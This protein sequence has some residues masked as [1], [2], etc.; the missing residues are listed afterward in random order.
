M[1]S[2]KWKIGKTS[3]TLSGS[4]RQSYTNTG[5]ALALPRLGGRGEKKGSAK[6]MG[7]IAFIDQSPG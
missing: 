2:K 4:G 6:L 3:N 1:A 5:S 7:K